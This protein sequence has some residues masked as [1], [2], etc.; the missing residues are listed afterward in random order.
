M[1]AAKQSLAFER[2]QGPADRGWRD[3][4]LLDEIG[5]RCL[6]GSEELL[7]NLFSATVLYQRLT[8]HRLCRCG[9]FHASNA[10]NLVRMSELT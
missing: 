4:E 7:Q 10:H 2:A 1:R 8:N 5:D 9:C 3:V 6:T